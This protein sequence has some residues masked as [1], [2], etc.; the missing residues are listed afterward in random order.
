MAGSLG[1]VSLPPLQS[2]P[3]VADMKTAAG[4]HR[5]LVIGHVGM[6]GMELL[7]V[8]DMFEVASELHV[9]AGFPA[10]Y[11]VEVASLAGGPLDLGRGLSL[12]GV[13]ALRDDTRAI[14]TLV[15]VGGLGA[16]EV[17]TADGE[18]VDAIRAAAARADRVVSVCTG[19]YLL[20]AAGLLDGRRATTHWALAERFATEYPAVVLERDA[21]YLRDGNVWTS[22]G[23]TAAQDLVLALVEEDLGPERALQLARMSVVYLRRAGG[24]SQFSVHLA[25]PPAR[26]QP[27]RDAQ[28]HILLHPGADLSIDVLAA[29]VNLSPRH[30]TRLF[31]SEVGMSPGS[32]IELVRLEAARRGLETTDHTLARIADDAGFGTAENLRRVF[33]SALG[34]SPGEYRRRFSPR[35][36]AA[37]IREPART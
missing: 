32:Y 11:E 1:F 34:V 24:Q 6:L 31:R 5:I 26:R 30:F 9:Q 33:V 3:I 15:V 19:A 23:V 14:G 27:I 22:A 28:Q 18:L 16:P 35:H 21:I 37:E 29:H 10:A 4:A 8:R 36:S 17:A 12:S 2:T 7:A 13:V 25:A 20:G